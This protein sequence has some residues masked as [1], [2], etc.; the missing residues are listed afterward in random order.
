MRTRYGMM[1]AL[2]LLFFV[3]PNCAVCAEKPLWELGVGLAVIQMPDYPGA[4]ESRTYVLPYP[5]FIYRGDI[6]KIEKESISGRLFKTDKLLLEFS[7]FGRA[8]V[9]SSRNAARS[10]MPDLDPT[11]EIGPSLNITLVDQ[12]QDHYK[13]NLTM[14]VRAFFSTNLSSLHHEGWVFS[15]KLVFEKNDLIPGT[16]LN[17]G[18]SAGPLFADSSYN[19]YYYSVDPAYATTARP[20]YSTGG[21]Y[22]GSTLTI[23]LNKGFEKLIVNAFVSADF[24]QGTIN[25]SSPLIRRNTSVMCG[26]AVSWIFLTSAKLV[27]AGR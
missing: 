3:L 25:G 16:G 7:L 21:G 5:Y 23:S 20:Q 18:I 22:S 26:L 14:P 10:G 4:D 8:P 12:P 9:D 17:L 11:F 15:P 13:L 27:P 1:T 2:L 24:L 6:L 19:G